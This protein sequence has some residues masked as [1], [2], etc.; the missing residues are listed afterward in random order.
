MK[1][2]ILLALLIPTTL[3]GQQ[4][5]SGNLSFTN[6]SEDDELIISPAVSFDYNNHSWTIGPALL[7]S[8]GDQ[9]EDR[10]PLKLTGIKVGYENFLHGKEAKWNLFHS[11][12]FIAQRVKDTQDSQFFDIASNTFVSN[13]I[14]QIDNRFYLGANLGVLLKLGDRLSLDKSIGIGLNAVLR[15][16]E[17]NIEQFNDTFISQRWLLKLGLRYEL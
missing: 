1:N 8:F 10:D 14:E 7:Y 11:F 3:F 5:S 4:I 16:T 12:D 17:S 9:L 6:L 15:D 2:W 13:D